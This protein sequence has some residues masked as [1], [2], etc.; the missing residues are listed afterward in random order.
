[1]SFA[2]IRTT[3]YLISQNADCRSPERRRHAVR[4]TSEGETGTPGHWNSWL[5]DRR[6]DAPLPW[7]QRLNLPPRWPRNPG[8]RTCTRACPNRHATNVSTRC[9]WLRLAKLIL[10]PNRIKLRG[11]HGDDR[12]L[13]ADQGASSPCSCVLFPTLRASCRKATSSP[14]RTSTGEPGLPTRAAAKRNVRLL[15]LP[16]PPPII[17]CACHFPTL[18]I[19]S[20]RPPTAMFTAS[21]ADYRKVSTSAT[22]APLLMTQCPYTPP[23]RAGD[24]RTYAA[25][26]AI[27]TTRRTQAR[28]SSASTDHARRSPSSHRVDSAMLST[29]HPADRKAMDTARRH[30]AAR[31]P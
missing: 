12:R 15:N 20:M 17:S 9:R 8:T 27:S 21:T 14:R 31:M 26:Q 2:A 1:M 16:L 10:A 7:Q 22:C 23:P 13:A 19:L 5:R 3:A 24:S 25:R 6:P 30:P 11:R 4:S 18:S 28:R 29:T